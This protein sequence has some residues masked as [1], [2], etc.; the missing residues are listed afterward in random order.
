MR[1]S[2]VNQMI[3]VDEQHPWHQSRLLLIKNLLKDIDRTSQVLD[4]GC[5]SGAVLKMLNDQGFTNL[6][7]IDSSKK[8]IE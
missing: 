1:K 8:C 3:E 4:F 2:A 5:G 7:G 6:S